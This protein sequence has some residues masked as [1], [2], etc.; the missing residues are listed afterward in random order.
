MSQVLHA[1]VDISA[2][3]VWVISFHVGSGIHMPGEDQIAKAGGKALD[4]GFNLG[5]D[6]PGRAVRDMA[7]CP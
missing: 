3:I 6:V 4:L 1:A 7:I 2:D 5:G